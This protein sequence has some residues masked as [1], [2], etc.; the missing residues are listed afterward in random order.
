MEPKVHWP[1]ITLERPMIAYL[2]AQ[3]DFLYKV[4]T[5]FPLRMN[6]LIF[7]FV[8]DILIIIPLLW[9]GSGIIWIENFPFYI[10]LKKGKNR[11]FTS[12]ST[13]R[14]ALLPTSYY[15]N[16]IFSTVWLTDRLISL[17][18]DFGEKM[19][20]GKTQ[21]GNVIRLHFHKVRFYISRYAHFLFKSAHF[22]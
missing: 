8:P 14:V 18:F 9:D 7:D 2:C 19:D 20:F 12:L 15:S 1:I 16:G 11:N 13:N 17:L 5:S 4:K 3:T 10:I 21:F 22:L 6:I